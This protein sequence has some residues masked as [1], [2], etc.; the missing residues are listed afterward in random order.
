[1]GKPSVPKAAPKAKPEPAPQAPPR[2]YSLLDLPWCRADLLALSIRGLYNM[3]EE[4]MEID[5]V[6]LESVRL[7]ADE[8]E[9]DVARLYRENADAKRAKG[10]AR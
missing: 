2:D 1:M 8:V 7:L 3:A 4:G 5:T 10:G 9:S 6:H